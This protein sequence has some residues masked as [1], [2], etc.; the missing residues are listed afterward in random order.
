MEY[1]G[2]ILDRSTGELVTISLG[3][4]VTITELGTRYGVGRREVRSV[5]R[6]MEF[7]HVEGGGSHQRHRLCEWVTSEGWGRRVQRRGTVPFDVISPAAQQW[8]HQRWQPT[9]EKMSALRSLPSKAALEA[10]LA[11]KTQ[12]DIFRSAVGRQSMSV[13]EQACWIKDRFPALAH[14]E[15]ADA[16][17]VSQQ[18]VSRLLKARE[19]GRRKM[20]DDRNKVVEF[21][22]PMVS[23]R[24]LDEP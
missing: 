11:F 10:L 12:R 13:E 23:L 4:W 2:S 9:L 21:K 6:S 18:L 14:E 1:T 7:L 19:Q 20:V 17:H 3:D 5:L 15:I 8:I 22:T 16:L 24:F